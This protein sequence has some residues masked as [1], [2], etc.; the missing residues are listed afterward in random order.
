MQPP[1]NSVCPTFIHFTLGTLLFLVTATVIAG[2]PRPS[3]AESP[4]EAISRIRNGTHTQ[5]PPPQT[6]YAS[7]PMGKGMTIENGTGYLVKVHFDGP[8][9]RTVDVPTGQSVG[10]DL[11]VGSYHVA[12][13]V[14]GSRIV[15]FYGEQIYQPHTHYWLKFFVQRKH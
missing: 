10:V 3:R 1:S 15:P 14:P 13:E 2:T 6:A 4:S 7:G 5:M 11:V 9:S 8:V 12:A